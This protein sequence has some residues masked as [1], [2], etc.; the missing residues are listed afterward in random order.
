M[1]T[2]LR[3]QPLFLL[4]RDTLSQLREK[5]NNDFFNDPVDVEEVRGMTVIMIFYSA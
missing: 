1:E 2:E 5:D 4:L 3:L